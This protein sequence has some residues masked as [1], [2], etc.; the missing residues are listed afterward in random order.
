S[1][2][3]IVVFPASGCDIIAKVF[4]RI[5]SFFISSDNPIFAILPLFIVSTTAA[6]F[7]VHQAAVPDRYYC[8]M[9]VI[10]TVIFKKAISQAVTSDI[11]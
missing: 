1:F 6:Q 4:L 11:Y 3:V 8:V 10:H 9:R 5:I 2:S 7:F